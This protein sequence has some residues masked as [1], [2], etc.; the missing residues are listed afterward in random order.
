MRGQWS[1]HEG[2]IWSLVAS[3]VGPI[4]AALG[5]TD[6]RFSCD[7]PSLTFASACSVFREN[8]FAAS[9]ERASWN[10]GRRKTVGACKFLASMTVFPQSLAM[11]AG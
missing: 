9:R 3:G 2:Q 11:N 6:S 4:T 8:R 7:I 5:K 1:F 10:N